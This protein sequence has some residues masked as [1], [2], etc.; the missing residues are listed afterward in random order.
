MENTGKQGRRYY[1]GGRCYCPDVSTPL[2]C[3]K[4][5]FERVTLYQSPKGAFFTVREST[6]DGLGID[7]AA[8][9]ALSRAAA[10]SF[11]DE[12]ATGI[13]IENYN[14]LFGEPKQG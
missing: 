4:G 6:V 14:K 13:D 9:E 3:H 12:H 8:V 5:I 11:M 1:V 10:R 2:C 7:G